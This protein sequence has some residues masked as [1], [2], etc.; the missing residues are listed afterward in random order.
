MI[1]LANKA[2]RINVLEISIDYL[3][4]KNKNVVF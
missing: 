3:D 2:K 4:N 1:Y